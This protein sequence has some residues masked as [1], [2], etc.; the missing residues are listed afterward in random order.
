MAKAKRASML[1][2]L[3]KADQESQEQKGK[4]I[5]EKED[6]ALIRFR[7]IGLP[8]KQIAEFMGMTE[9]QARVR[10]HRALL[11]RPE[12]KNVRRT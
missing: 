12:I 9:G 4:T 2:D 10:H 5:K 1:P 7:K 6:N 3:L 8:F 11:S